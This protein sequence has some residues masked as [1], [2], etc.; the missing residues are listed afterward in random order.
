M[1]L[2]W[3]WKKRKTQVSNPQLQ[4]CLLDSTVVTIGVIVIMCRAVGGA[5]SVVFPPMLGSPSP[6]E[7]AC[8]RLKISIWH[9]LR[10]LNITVT[11]CLCDRLLPTLQTTQ[12]T[13]VDLVYLF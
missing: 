9:F 4:T 3:L 7:S 13:L 2:A 1:K 10:G 5:K 8:L 12:V 6:S 11:L